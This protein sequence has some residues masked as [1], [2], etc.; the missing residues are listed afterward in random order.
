M[1]ALDEVELVHFERVQFQLK[2]FDMVSFKSVSI[3]GLLTSFYPIFSALTGLLYFIINRESKL[4]D[5]N[6]PEV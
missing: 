2:N 5:F 1:I 6:K 4:D 3:A